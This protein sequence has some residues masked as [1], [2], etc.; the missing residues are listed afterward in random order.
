MAKQKISVTRALV[1]LKSK[2]NDL[3]AMLS[4]SSKPILGGIA[5]KSATTIKVGNNVTSV[6][7]FNKSA[8]AF[9]QKLE[10]T[11][12]AVQTLRTA[13]QT[14]NFNTKVTIGGQEMS[15][16]DVLI[17][18]QSV[19][20]HKKSLLAYILTS[21]SSMGQLFTMAEKQYNEQV[22]KQVANFTSGNTSGQN[23]EN[24]KAKIE[25]LKELSA[26][27][28]PV[29]ID[30]LKLSQ[31]AEELQKEISDFETEVDFVVQETN[32]KTEVEVDLS[33]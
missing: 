20:G 31:W 27:R 2:T 10:A 1:L 4:Y 8:V 21:A 6:E 12:K 18:K 25:Q 28:S 16:A 3:E 13:I 9:K 17:Y 30:P 26:D 19:L 15:L 14:A 29:L 11:F 5:E 24:F 23:A 7:D 32:A 33:F 22:E